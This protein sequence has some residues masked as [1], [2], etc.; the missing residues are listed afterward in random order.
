MP[1][2]PLGPWGTSHGDQ[3][4]AAIEADNWPLFA[5]LMVDGYMRVCAMQ[6][7]GGEGVTFEEVTASVMQVSSNNLVMLAAEAL[8]RLYNDGRRGE[9]ERRGQD[10]G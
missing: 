9:R 5:Q 10:A 2:N 4:D 3:M 6:H 7:P 1:D 8:T